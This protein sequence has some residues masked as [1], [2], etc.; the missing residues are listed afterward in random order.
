[1]YHLLT[2]DLGEADYSTQLA[3]FGEYQR[4][5]CALVLRFFSWAFMIAVHRTCRSAQPEYNGA[6]AQLVE[7][8]NGIE[9]VEGSNPSSSTRNFLKTPNRNR[10]G[11][12]CCTE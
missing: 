5:R 10:V 3:N 4:N 11:V 1:M 12:F 2:S 7:R 9:E 8:F 6:V